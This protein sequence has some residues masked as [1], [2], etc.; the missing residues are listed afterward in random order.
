MMSSGK[1]VVHKHLHQDKPVHWDLMFE[2]GPIL[3]T[4]RVDIPP[5]DWANRPANAVRI[6]DH[7]LK[8]LTYE[9]P[10]NQGRGSVRIAD[11]GTYKLI[12]DAPREILLEFEGKVL[13]GQFSLILVR[14]NHWLLTRLIP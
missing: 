14:D 11:A 10:V 3:E 13:T 12:S 2:A 6:F 7:S 8:F 9:G 5:Q 1:F 4:Y